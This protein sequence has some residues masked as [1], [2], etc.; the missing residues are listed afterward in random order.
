MEVEKSLFLRVREFVSLSRSRHFKE[1]T[2]DE[3]LQ[4]RYLP[5]RNLF[6]KQIADYNNEGNE[7]NLY[8]LLERRN[9]I[10]N[11]NHQ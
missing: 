6:P 4:D 7:F 5:P 10:S 9:L 3:S 1:Q 11:K 2:W 8:K